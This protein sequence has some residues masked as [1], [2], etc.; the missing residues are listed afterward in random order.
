MSEI[1]TL[2][3]VCGGEA[4]HVCSICGRHVCNEHYTAT[5]G[6]CTSC[7]FGRKQ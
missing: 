3:H 5:R 4:K 2:C 7:I 6:V 1:K